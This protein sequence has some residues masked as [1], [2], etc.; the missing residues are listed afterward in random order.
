MKPF[1]AALQSHGGPS[2]QVWLNDGMKSADKQDPVVLGV[3]FGSLAFVATHP[4]SLIDCA[5]L[6]APARCG[7]PFRSLAAQL[8]RGVR[9]LEEWFSLGICTLTP[10]NGQRP[11]DSRPKHNSYSFQRGL[12]AA[13]V[14]VAIRVPGRSKLSRCCRWAKCIVRTDFGGVAATLIVKPRS[15]TARMPSYEGHQW[16]RKR[17]HER[18]ALKGQHAE[19]DSDKAFRYSREA[20]APEA[21]QVGTDNFH[22]LTASCLA[23]EIHAPRSHSGGAFPSRVIAAAAACLR[24]CDSPLHVTEVVSQQREGT[25][26]VAKLRV[27]QC[28]SNQGCCAQSGLLHISPACPGF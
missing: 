21:Y 27:L 11:P 6:V 20:R 4:V 13:C 19:A 28:P 7:R 14:R 23:S 17:G 8:L 24:T 1:K 10:G 22:S 25:P 16:K 26:A 9:I 5:C 12:L 18:H 2:C 3:P 15:G